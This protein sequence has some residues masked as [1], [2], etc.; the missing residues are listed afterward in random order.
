MDLRQAY[1]DVSGLRIRAIESGGKTDHVFTYKRT[2]DGQVVEIDSLSTEAERAVA[3]GL[4]VRLD[5]PL[6][7]FQGRRDPVGAVAGRASRSGSTA[8]GR[9]CS[10]PTGLS[11]AGSGRGQSGSA[12]KA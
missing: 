8:A 2:I 10:T 6:L 12:A 7:R 1:L 3:L 11:R 9:Y 5:Q 4:L